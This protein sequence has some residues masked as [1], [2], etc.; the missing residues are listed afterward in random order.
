MPKIQTWIKDHNEN[1]VSDATI[2]YVIRKK[3]MPC[4]NNVPCETLC[5]YLS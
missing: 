1:L 3:I 5:G 4:K 2:H